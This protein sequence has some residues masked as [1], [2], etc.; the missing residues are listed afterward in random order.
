[1]LSLLR[2]TKILGYAFHGGY[3]QGVSSDTG[4]E[5]G[6]PL[7]FQYALVP[8]SGDWS[9]AGVYRAGMEFN[10]PLVTRKALLHGGPLPKKWGLLTYRLPT[11]S[12][13]R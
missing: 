10:H 8:Y 2:S 13:Q 11:L 5:L 9:E 4:L 1:M 3:E 7:T 12:S 6:M